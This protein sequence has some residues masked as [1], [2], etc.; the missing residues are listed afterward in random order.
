V[1]AGR[2]F[3]IQALA[4]LLTFYAMAGAWLAMMLGSTRDPRLHW[5]PLAV[6]GAVFALSAGGAALAV[7][8][9]QPRA[10]MMLTA[11]AV[12]GAA[13]CAAMPLAVRGVESDRATWVGAVGGGLLFAAFLLLAARYIQLYLRSRG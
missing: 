13:L 10:P 7:W 2:P 11:C 12:I 1:I 6:G 3:L 8:R 4:G 9:Q 5:A